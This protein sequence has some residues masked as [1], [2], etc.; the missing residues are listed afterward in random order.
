MIDQYPFLKE[1]FPDAGPDLLRLL[2]G[3]VENA[4]LLRNDFYTMR[5]WLEVAGERTGS[6]CMRSCCCCW[7]RWRKAACA[8]TSRR[9][10]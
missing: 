3:G 1:I 5:D 9:H 6:R 10:R 7:S 8:S 4:M 2:H